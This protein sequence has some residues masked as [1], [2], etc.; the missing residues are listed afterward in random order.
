MRHSWGLSFPGVSR[1]TPGAI[2][3]GRGEGDILAVEESLSSPGYPG[4]RAP[5]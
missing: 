3:Q 5:Q 1:L 4:S 2:G